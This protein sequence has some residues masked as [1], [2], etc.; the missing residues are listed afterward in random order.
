MPFEEV[1]DRKLDAILQHS[2]KIKCCPRCESQSVNIRISFRVYGG[3]GAQVICEECGY[4][5]K[6]HEIHSQ[7][8][9]G[10]RIA[11][12]VTHKS[13]VRAMWGAIDQWNN[14]ERGD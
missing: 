5:T 3:H 11:T 13:M 7:F 8:S 1:S 14:I 10:S 2:V 4:R 6:I 12:P 9:S